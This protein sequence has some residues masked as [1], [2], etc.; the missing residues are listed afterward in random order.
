MRLPRGGSSLRLRRRPSPRAG[1][2]L[3]GLLRHAVQ[4]EAG[5]F[6]LRAADDQRPPPQAAVRPGRQ[7]AGRRAVHGRRARG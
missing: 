2:R 7:R 1:D 5:S 3:Q 6:L 4:R